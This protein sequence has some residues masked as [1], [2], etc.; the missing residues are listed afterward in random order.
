MSIWNERY[1]DEKFGL[2]TNASFKYFQDYLKLDFPRTIVKLHENIVRKTQENN[3]KNNQRK[4]IIKVKTLYD[5]SAKWKWK[6]REKEYDEYLKNVHFEIKEKEVMEWESDQLKK[7]MMRSDYH[8]DTFQKIHNSN[9]K[10]FPLSK[11]A[12]AEY[13]N[14]KAYNENVNNV[15][16]LL[17]GGVDKSETKNMNNGE[18]IVNQKGDFNFNQK[19]KFENEEEKLERYANY[20]KQIKE[21]IGD[22]TSEELNK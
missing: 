2:E 20:F 19:V 14:Q 17:Y 9:E 4:K 13:Q 7:S 16:T 5:Y 11:K 22:S 18:M 6:K 21:D 1:V 10:E 3:Q 15:Y 12:Y 8:N